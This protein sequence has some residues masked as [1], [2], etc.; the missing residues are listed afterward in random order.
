[1]NL[2]AIERAIGHMRE[3]IDKML[4]DNVTHKQLNNLLDG[5]R[6]PI[7]EAFN[8][9]QTTDDLPFETDQQKIV[10]QLRFL[11]AARRDYCHSCPQTATDFHKMDAMAL[12]VHEEHESAS[13]LASI[14]EGSNDARGW[15]PSWR[16][17]EW[18]D[19][20]R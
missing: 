13:W 7:L 2:E 10:A 11:A 8:R 17:S 4:V 16:W 18:E 3:Q 12:A 1:M 6:R 5:V 15:L 19:K 9:K 20:R 14:I